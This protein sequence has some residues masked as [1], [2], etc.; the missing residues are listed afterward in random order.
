MALSAIIVRGVEWLLSPSVVTMFCVITLVASIQL[1]S[2][3][4]VLVPMLLF[5]KSHCFGASDSVFLL[6]PKFF[7]LLSL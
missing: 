3:S 5:T 2:A 6:L 7:E 1:S 4:L